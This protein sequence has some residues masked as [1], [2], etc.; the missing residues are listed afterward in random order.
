MEPCDFACRDVLSFSSESLRLNFYV[1]S[2]RLTF[3]APDNL[4]LNAFDSCLPCVAIRWQYTSLD[5]NW[6][7]I[8]FHYLNSRSYCSSP[9]DSGRYN[10]LSRI[11]LLAPRLRALYYINTHS[12]KVWLLFFF[13]GKKYFNLGICMLKY[14]F[15]HLDR[16]YDIKTPFPDLWTGKNVSFNYL[17]TLW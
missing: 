2:L 17:P 11:K 6:Q 1:V 7:S 15:F 8:C 4:A 13:L 3:I 9:K 5:I 10:I 14:R 16:H 12:R